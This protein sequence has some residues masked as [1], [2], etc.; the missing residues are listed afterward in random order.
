M[1]LS[2]LN[3]AIR[4]SLINRSYAR[5]DRRLLVTHQLLVPTLS[6]GIK[7]GNVTNRRCFVASFV[8]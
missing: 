2:S 4:H 3:S 7:R 8:K 1:T 6:M 5:P